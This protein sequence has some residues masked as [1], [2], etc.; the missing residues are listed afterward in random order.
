VGNWKLLLAPLANGFGRRANVVADDFVDRL[1]GR[2]EIK[3]AIHFRFQN[4]F[5]IT[6]SRTR[7][8]RRAPTPLKHWIGGARKWPARLSVRMRSVSS[9]NMRHRLRRKHRFMTATHRRLRPRSAWAMSDIVSVAAASA[10][11]RSNLNMF[12]LRQNFTVPAGAPFNLAGDV[13]SINNRDVQTLTLGVNY[14]FNW[15]SNWHRRIAA[16]VSAIN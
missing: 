6:A 10:A 3:K 14:L 12:I 13:I 9:H 4:F 8:S 16:H 2:A 11:K 5:D 1:T 15:G 7:I